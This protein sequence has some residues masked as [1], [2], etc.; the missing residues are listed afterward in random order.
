MENE[1]EKM[2][3]L[4]LHA[5]GIDVGSKSHFSAI[6]QGEN[7]FKEFEIIQLEEVKVELHEG[8]FHN[9]VGKVIRFVGK[10]PE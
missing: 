9:G 8:D 5:A 6:G 1:F 2:P 4:N 7:D 10:K 3:V